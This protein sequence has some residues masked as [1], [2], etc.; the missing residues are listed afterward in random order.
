MRAV[1]SGPSALIGNGILRGHEMKYLFFLAALAVIA[2]LITGAI[3]LQPSSSENQTI[4]IQIDKGRVKQNA[5]AALEKGKK[6][7][8]GAESALHQATRETERN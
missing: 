1:A 3:K 5:A 6:V 2:L 8:E 4:T 7:I